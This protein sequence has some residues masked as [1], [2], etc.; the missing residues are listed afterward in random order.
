M[1]LT[2]Q[3]LTVETFQEVLDAI[4]TSL[5]E[6]VSPSIEV[7]DDTA[8][9]QANQI[10]ATQIALANELIQDIYDQRDINKAEGKALDDN[11]SWLGITRQAESA[12]AGEQLFTGDDNTTIVLGS[13][14][15]NDSTGD[16]YSLD[17]LVLISKNACRDFQFIVITLDVPN[18][19]TVTVQGVD[20]DY[21]AQAL[22][23][24]FDIVDGLAVLI[25]AA[26]N[27]TATST[28]D[29]VNSFG[30]VVVNDNTDVIASTDTRLRISQATTAGDITGVVTGPIS[31]PANTLT[32]INTPTSGWTSTNNF[33]ALNIGRN[34]E[35]DAELRTRAIN[36]RASTGT[37][38]VT[39]MVSGLLQLSGVSSATIN[40]QFVGLGVGGT[41]VSVL[42]AVNLTLYT[43]FVNG[44]A[45]TGD[46]IDFTSDASAT[47]E[48][49]AAGLT[50]EINVVGLGLY[51]A[52]DN[53]DGTLTI[54][55][56][57]LNAIEV[58]TTEPQL[59]SAVEVS[60]GQP[61]GSI[62][63][64]VAGGVDDDIA[65]QI[66]DT[67]PAGVEVWALRTFDYN[68]EIP[69]TAR[70]AN[71]KDINGE[72]VF[73]EWNSPSTVDMFTSITFDIFD[74]SS[75]P[76]NSAD[77][78][79]AVQNAI[80]DFGNALGAGEDVFPARFEQTVYSAVSGISNVLITINTI[81]SVPVGVPVPIDS[82]EEALF[83]IANITVVGTPL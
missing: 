59:D 1:A 32:V 47:V 79:L 6:E 58:I 22:D 10:F 80:I 78:I 12:T 38:T 4:I 64:V 40:E 50:N 66:Y 30:S 70:S 21:P 77:A 27:L 46:Q 65:Q 51:S 18:T 23:T 74:T 67:K 49:I 73:V 63:C 5:Q 68:S 26:T 52:I 28:D 56:P 14:I 3:G 37:A 25:T 19:Y 31:A 42:T 8:L 33:T 2:T 36:F 16:L 71:A 43:L 82:D 17:D 11:V 83:T 72:N 55:A 69:G 34:E 7:G 45:T 20:F 48:E 76:E 81:P 24:E 60:E 29:G 75:Y 44:D 13:L 15:G 39:A 61:A 9:G 54:S 41:E 53:L 57:S 62:Q 35:T